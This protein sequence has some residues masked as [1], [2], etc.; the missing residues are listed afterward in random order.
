MLISFIICPS[1][2]F[3]CMR[4]IL[5]DFSVGAETH[6]VMHIEMKQ[7]TTL[8]SRL[9]VMNKEMLWVIT[10]VF[11]EMKERTTTFTSSLLGL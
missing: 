11:Y 2:Y 6:I 3:A 9:W 5:F 8:T 7:G 4:L 10:G 1:D